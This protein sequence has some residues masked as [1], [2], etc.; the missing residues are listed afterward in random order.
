ML[1]PDKSKGFK[2]SHYGLEAHAPAI[3]SEICLD[4]GVASKLHEMMLKLR[5][6]KQ[7][8]NI[9]KLKASSAPLPKREPWVSLL[10]TSPPPIINILASRKARKLDGIGMRGESGDGMEL[11]PLRF[12]LVCPTCGASKEC[13]QV[14][15]F[16]NVARG[17]A[18]ST[19]RRSTTSTRWICFH[20]TP[21]TDCP[22]CRHVGFRCGSQSLVEHTGKSSHAS[23]RIRHQSS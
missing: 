3:V 19:C 16:T 8:P 9:N 21:W 22:V 7:G 12:S 6:T 2:L 23:S 20:R 4:A 5:I 15:L 18:C 17:L 11:Q 10:A 14:K 1:R 13:A